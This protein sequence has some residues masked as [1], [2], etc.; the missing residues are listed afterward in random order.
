MWVNCYNIFN[1]ALPLVGREMGPEALELH[2]RPRRSACISERHKDTVN[3][4][5]AMAVG[6]TVTPNSARPPG[7]L[8][9][10]PF[11]AAHGRPRT[12][13]APTSA[14]EDTRVDIAEKLRSL[15]N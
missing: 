5:V 4:Y 7:A 14:R 2:R 9:I 11:V 15:I 10:P 13:F 6:E 3:A 12:D 1:A 8:A